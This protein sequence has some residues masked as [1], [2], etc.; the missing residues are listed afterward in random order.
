MKLIRWRKAGKTLPGVIVNNHHYDVSSLGEDYNEVFF[1][2]GGLQRL[3]KF[4]E[5]HPQNL[6]QLDDDVELDSPIARPSKIVCIGLN[7]ADH[8]RET[9]A[10]PPAEP[11]IFL[12]STTALCGPFDAIIIPKNSK[13]TDWEVE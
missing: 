10:Q 6:K 9:K 12:K 11:V 13:K 8:A 1:E 5:D 3:K 2:T 7:Y 4:I